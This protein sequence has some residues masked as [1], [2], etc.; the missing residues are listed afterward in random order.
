MFF[1][2]CIKSIAHSLEKS[3]SFIVSSIVG[4]LPFS[5]IIF[6]LY[7]SYFEYFSRSVVGILTRFGFAVLIRCCISLS[8]CQYK[9]ACFSLTVFSLFIFKIPLYN[10]IK[11]C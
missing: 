1:V 3:N 8:I 4:I 10:P 6:F 11:Q 2:P 5:S 7:V 9:Y